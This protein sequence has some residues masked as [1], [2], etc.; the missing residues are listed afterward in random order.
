M[1]LDELCAALGYEFE[2]CGG[3]ALIEGRS[4][5]LLPELDSLCFD[6]RYL[7]APGGFET[8]E[9]SLLLEPEAAARLLGLGLSYDGQLV[10]LELSGAE[11]LHG[12]ED[13][14]DIY[15]DMDLV[16]WLPHV[17][18]AEAC[19]QPIAGQ[20]A[21]GNVVMNRVNSPDFP[22]SVMEVIYD[23]HNTIQFD[24]VADGSIKNEPDET[25]K[26]AAYLCMEGYN[27]A[28][29]SLFFVNPAVG[30]G[31]WFERELELVAEIGD[32]CFYR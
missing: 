24:P 9:E 27:T 30:D 19:Q 1:P 3:G 25:A 31:S 28:G 16:Y 23:V 12:C 8:G 10:Y 11:L 20:I 5:E 6:G 18:W 15:F 29:D 22:D 26:I 7:Y 21:V 2:L 17:I 13:Y 4:L 32:H 14:Y